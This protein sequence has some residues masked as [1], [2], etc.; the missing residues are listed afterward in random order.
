[1]IN[2][3]KFYDNAEELKSLILLNNKN[4]S[5]IYKWE[6]KISGEL[7][8]GSAVDLNKRMLEYYR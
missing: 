8:I 3:V 4:K 2:P 5:G 7:Y 6:N 1:M